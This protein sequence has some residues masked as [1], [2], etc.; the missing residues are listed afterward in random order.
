MPTVLNDVTTNFKVVGCDYDW[1]DNNEHDQY[2]LYLV[3]AGNTPSDPII[4]YSDIYYGDR[5][6]TD[7]AF[8]QDEN[9]PNTSDSYENNKM[10]VNITESGTNIYVKYDD[11]VLP[12]LS[13]AAKEIQLDKEN[14]QVYVVW[15][16]NYVDEVTGENMVTRLLIAQDSGK[17]SFSAMEFPGDGSLV[18]T[19]DGTWKTDISYSAGDNINISDQRVISTPSNTVTRVLTAQ[20][21]NDLPDSKYTDGIVYCVTDGDPSQDIYGVINDETVSEMSTWSSSKVNS[22]LGAI[23]TAGANISINDRVI[24]ATD[25][26]YVAGNG[27][28]ISAQNVISSLL[29]AGSGISIVDNVIST[30]AASYIAGENISISSSNVISAVDTKYTAG[31]NISISDS[32]IISAS[33]QKLK[34]T[35]SSS[36]NYYPIILNRST[37]ATENTA[38]IDEMFTYNPGTDYF[39]L[40]TSGKLGF[41]SGE[42]EMSSLDVLSY[43]YSSSRPSPHHFSMFSSPI[44]SNIYIGSKNNT[45]NITMRGNLV[46][47]GS[48]SETR[49][50]NTAVATLTLPFTPSSSAGQVWTLTVSSNQGSNVYLVA[51]GASSGIVVSQMIRGIT[52]QDVTVGVSSS[53]ITIRSTGTLDTNISWNKFIDT[54]SA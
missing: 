38:Y 8:I 23:Y 28:N 32:N 10:Y 9:F 20:E 50:I 35:V 34:T 21:Y 52:T 14:N 33:D 6:A 18:L 26:T 41:L 1:Y 36:D 24:S 17:I 5:K 31:N 37:T 53:S 30:D 4:A 51:V 39:R 11:I 3:N 2:T 16:D 40:P 44:A 25:T 13:V 46:I 27:I 29:T 48:S 15:N 47:E 49:T 19:G 42:D 7:I 22:E 54:Y 12:T 45:R 43:S